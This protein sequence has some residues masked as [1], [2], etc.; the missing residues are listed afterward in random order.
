MGRLHR[1]RDIFSFA[2]SIATFGYRENEIFENYKKKP[3]YHKNRCRLNP[4][5]RVTK[6]V[7]KREQDKQ[8]DQ[9]SKE[10]GN[11]IPEARFQHGSLVRKC[12]LPVPEEPDGRTYWIHKCNKNF[13]FNTPIGDE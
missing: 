10:V 6:P 12:P 5:M 9:V 1:R 13:W 8:V 2:N 7:N 3:G 11:K 4:L